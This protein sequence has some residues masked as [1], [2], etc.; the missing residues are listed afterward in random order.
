MSYFI[1]LRGSGY[2]AVVDPYVL[3]GDVLANPPLMASTPYEAVPQLVKGRD[4][5]LTTHGFNV[6]Y[7]DGLRCLGRLEGL[8]APTASEFMFGVLWPG[9]WVIPAINYPFTEKI[10]TQTG[11]RLSAFCNRWLAG[12]RS[13]SFVSHSLGARVVLQTISGLNCRARNV[14]LTAGA[15]EAD[16]L[17][18]EYRVAD[19]NSNA[20]VTLS[21]MDDRVL[22]FAYPVGD[23]IADILDADHKPFE[24][25]LGREGP[26]IPFGPSIA[27]DEIPDAP[28]YDHGDYLPPSDLAQPVPD[29]GAKWT[30]TTTFMARSFRDQTQTW[31][32]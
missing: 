19:A 31:P 30:R 21:S 5:L 25:A 8:I 4:V 29:P 16:C 15:I 13:I 32:G 10:A 6:N 2:G 27:A 14:C 20:V 22:E 12:A 17:T 9:D 3:E 18:A 1:N 7:I 23:L 26:T 11:Q 24:R 28:P